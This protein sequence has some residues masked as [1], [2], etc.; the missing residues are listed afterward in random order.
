[1]IAIR[2]MAYLTLSYDHRVIDGSLG[3]QFLQHIVKHIETWDMN[4]QLF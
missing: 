3:G 2:E 1:M 4:R